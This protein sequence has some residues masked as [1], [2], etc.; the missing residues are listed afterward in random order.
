MNLKSYKN[1][2]KTIGIRQDRVA[3]LLGLK[4]GLFNEYLNG[5]RP[6]PEKHRVRLHVIVETLE[7]TLKS[8]ELLTQN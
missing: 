5:I 3:E 6:M 8:L 7:K 2:L 1:R 4:R